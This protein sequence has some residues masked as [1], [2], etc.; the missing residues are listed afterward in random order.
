MD[1]FWALA[2]TEEIEYNET[3]YQTSKKLL[4]T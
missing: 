3:D 2:K 1:E 4:Q